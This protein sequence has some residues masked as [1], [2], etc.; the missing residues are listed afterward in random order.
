MLLDRATTLP[1]GLRVRLR[2]ARGSD[3][4]RLLELARGWEGSPGDVALLHALRQ[5]PRAYA[6]ICATAWVDGSEALLGF[7]AGRVRA[8]Q[9]DIL[10]V[11][12]TRTR[13]LRA[14]LAQALAERTRGIRAVR[15]VA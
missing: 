1:D 11:D 3:R 8:S 10:L 13:F 6:A 5:D 2:L 9:P 15:V 14:V 4:A 12:P 7:A